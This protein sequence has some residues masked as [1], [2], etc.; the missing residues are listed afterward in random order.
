M[1]LNEKPITLDTDTV[2]DWVTW[3]TRGAILSLFTMAGS[4]FMWAMNAETRLHD[5]EQSGTRISKLEANDAANMSLIVDIAVV[6]SK[7]DAQDKQ[8][9]HITALLEAAR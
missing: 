7:L 5:V 1:P 9:T 8:L 4:F 6:K 2:R 3:A